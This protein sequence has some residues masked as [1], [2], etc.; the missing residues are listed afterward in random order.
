MK[1][2]G[3][4][5]V[6]LVMGC[7]SQLPIAKKTN[8]LMGDLSPVGTFTVNRRQNFVLPHNASIY[9]ASPVND[10]VTDS[11]VDVN[12]L[13]AER[14]KHGFAESFARVYSGLNKE[15]VEQALRSGRE[16]GANFVVYGFVEQWG[17]IKPLPQSICDKGDD[18]CEKNKQEAN[19]TGEAKIA[20]SIFE[21]AS[22][23]IVDIVT[24]RSNRGISAYLYEDH[25]GPLDEIV[26]DLLNSFTD[27]R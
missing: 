14:M 13:F 21:S 18:A 10:I 16:I 3:L 9:V 4:A 6:L 12:G 2:A 15:R 26:E 24:V 20:I 27:R 11:G 19:N 1:W 17:D 5:F 8:A 7:Q 22:G 23:Q 25:Q